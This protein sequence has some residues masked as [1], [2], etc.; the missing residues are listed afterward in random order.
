[1]NFNYRRAYEDFDTRQW[2]RISFQYFIHFVS[3]DLRP[4][5]ESFYG[6]VSKF[7]KLIP[8]ANKRVAE[9]IETDASNFYGFNVIALLYG[10]VVNGADIGAIVLNNLIL[11]GV[12]PRRALESDPP[13]P[14]S[15]FYV[16]YSARKNV[17]SAPYQNDLRDTKEVDHFD[18]LYSQ[19]VEDVKSNADVRELD[20]TLG[21][22]LKTCPT[23]RTA[24]L[25]MIQEPWTGV[26]FWK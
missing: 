5:L 21:A 4:Q 7:N 9:L 11:F 16:R 15:R 12:H 2:S 13:N 19:L 1:M 22:I 6:L 23:V 18:E 10:A 25:R 26:G 20:K 3:P 17:G 14:M 24:V 8:I